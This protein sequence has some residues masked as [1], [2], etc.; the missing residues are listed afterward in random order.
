[1][2]RDRLSQATVGRGRLPLW[3]LILLL[4]GALGAAGW[5]AGRRLGVEGHHRT[6]ELVLDY[7]E[8]SRLAQAVGRPPREVVAAFQAAGVTTLAV[9][10]Y[11]VVDYLRNGNVVAVPGRELV[12][13]QALGRPAPAF[14][15]ELRRQGLF[16]PHSVYLLAANAAAGREFEAALARRFTPR[17]V[18]RR[19][20]SGRVVWEV[21]RDLEWLLGQNL[22]LAPDELRL[23]AHLGLAVAPRWSNYPDLTPAKL[24]GLVAQVPAGLGSV[25]IFSGKRILG[26]PLLLGATAAALAERGLY[27]GLVEF[28]DQDGEEEL[29]R[30]TG[31]RIVRVHSITAGEMEKIKPPVAAA[32]DLRAVRER[33]IRALYL[34]PFLAPEQVG[35]EE[36]ALRFNLDYVRDLK[37]GFAAE[38]FRLGRA[39]PLASLP[40]P[41]VVL[42]LLCLGALAGG[43]LLLR[44]F[45]WAGWAVEAGIVVLGTLGALAGTRA[46]FD[47]LVRQL[48]ALGTG[49][50]L[51][52]LA[53]LVGRDVLRRAPGPGWLRALLGFL[54]ATVCSLAGAALVVGFLGENR[55]LVAV[56]TFSGVKVLHAAPLLLVWFALARERLGSEGRPGGWRRLGADVRRVLAGPVTWEQAW[57]V[58][59][60]AGV[61]A[62]YLLR[63]G[64]YTNVPTP[65]WER[66]VREALER[67]LVVRPRT[68]EFLLG[69]PALVL[70][71]LLE[72]GGLAGVKL[73]PLYVVGTIGQLSL[74]DTFS[75]IHTPLWISAVRT[76]LGLLLGAA[77]GLA[78]WGLWV[79]GERLGRAAGARRRRPEPGEGET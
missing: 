13:D 19:V 61:L 21:P 33:G 28:A 62:F 1:M 63:T 53:V 7:P 73:W 2:R 74:V 24:A 37:A 77:L 26:Y 72:A 18:T 52:T 54:A 50:T 15:T 59:L 17:E 31:Y 36:A 9:G 57:L 49:V 45:V 58:L 48:F 40:A 20:V 41:G 16:H 44:R 46:G 55:F 42:T 38:G 56:A 25:A 79:A 23:A 35:R 27:F 68:K 6:V 12:A 69:H 4:V 8:T 65:G 34:R 22:G 47:L 29:A 10:E 30:R 43:V 76:E 51:S 78:A 14:L 70:A 75:H 67:L 39:V 3:L 66:A 32:R 60:G 64:T 11:T 71:L 5:V